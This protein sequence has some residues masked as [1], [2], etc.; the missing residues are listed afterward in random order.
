MLQNNKEET[1][2]RRSKILTQLEEHGQINVKQLS[3][4]FNV[5]E[6]TIRNDLTYLENKNLLI[7]SRGGA[8]KQQRVGIDFKLTVKT[9]KYQ[10]EKQKIGRLAVDLIKEDDTIILDSGTTT[11]EIARN[12]GRF[13]KLTVITNALN[14]A[15]ILSDFS[16]I[17]VIILGGYLRANSLSLVGPM[18][19][20]AL[21]HYYVDKVFLGVDGIDSG[22]GISTP[23]IEEAY[24]NRTMIEMSKEVFVVTDSSKFNKRSFALI[25]PVNALD[26]VITDSGI[27]DDEKKN[28]QNAEVQIIEAER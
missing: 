7:R 11:A 4:Y 18:A 14:I 15:C 22:H 27:P 20:S 17:R 23:N 3:Q 21:R 13:N 6:V 26:F 10:T 8:I 9:K 12:L 16:N 28:L 2:S 19:E 5:S 24:L 25:V 1:V